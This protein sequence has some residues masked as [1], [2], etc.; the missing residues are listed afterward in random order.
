MS[1][2]AALKS[3][4]LF[5]RSA[6]RRGRFLAAALAGLAVFSSARALDLQ[7]AVPAFVDG[8][9]RFEMTA[10]LDAPIDEV[11]RILRNYENYPTLDSRIMEATVLDRPEA[12]VA[13][14][15]TTLRACF[16]PV[17]RTVKRIERVEEKP[18]ELLAITDASRSQVKL[19]ETH[20]RLATAGANQTLV[21]Y[22]TRLQPAFWVPA[23]VARRLMLETLADATLE[24]FYSV[25]QQAR[26]ASAGVTEQ[27][28]VADPHER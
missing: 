21:N 8:E 6:A 5:C 9:Y 7:R 27:P 28:V 19:G 3:R 15:A 11:E 4:L 22:R 10:V 18:R 24:L 12:D 26:E 25:E 16:G 1:G 23:I 20:M 13:I 2:D 14:L 17:C